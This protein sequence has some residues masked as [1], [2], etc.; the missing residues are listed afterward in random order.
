MKK[1]VGCIIL[2]LV[3]SIPFGFSQTVNIIYSKTAQA[4]YAA[5]M[6]EKAFVNKG[7]TLSTENKAPSLTA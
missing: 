6:L 7:Y 5:R 4:S 3:I 1:I 2:F